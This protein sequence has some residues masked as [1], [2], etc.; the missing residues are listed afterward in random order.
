MYTIEEITSIVKGKLLLQAP[1]SEEIEEL[2][3]DSRKIA[4]A[5]TSLFFALKGDRH[6]GHRFIESCTEQGV[7]NFIVS[8]F[9]DEW[10]NLPANF[11]VVADTLDALQQLA[12]HHREQFTIPVIGITGSNGKTIVKEWLY[13]LMRDDKN[14]VRSPKSYNSQTGVPLSVWQMSEEHNLAIFE[15]GLSQPGEMGR[16]EKIIQ[17]TT[18]IFTPQIASNTNQR[19]TVSQ[20]NF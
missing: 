8:E 20:S 3:T 6:D 19:L 1:K 12:T 9:R 14:I 16:L 15:A 4:H 2:L 18:G 17:P 13:Q 11:I 5:E 10:K 7:P